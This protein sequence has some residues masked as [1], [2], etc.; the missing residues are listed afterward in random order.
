MRL[1]L[2][3]LDNHIEDVTHVGRVAIPAPADAYRAP[4]SAL[5]NVDRQEWRPDVDH[6]L[7]DLKQLRRRSRLPIERDR[8]Q[9]LKESTDAAE[10]T[11]IRTFVTVA[12]SLFP[13]ELSYHRFLIPSVT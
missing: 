3:Q 11:C 5:P 6:R 8:E 12:Q 1:L 9:P 7:I 13:R 2:P 4:E 10:W